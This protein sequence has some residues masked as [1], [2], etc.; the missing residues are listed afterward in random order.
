[1][2]YEKMA[3]KEAFDLVKLKR[4]ITRPNPTFVRTLLQ[5]ELTLYGKNSIEGK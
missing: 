2:N 3:L 5:H 1:M 4:M